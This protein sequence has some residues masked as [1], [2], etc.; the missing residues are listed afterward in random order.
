MLMTN[1]LP[2]RTKGTRYDLKVERDFDAPPQA[3]DP[4]HHLS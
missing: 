1:E 4:P 2:Q 3:V